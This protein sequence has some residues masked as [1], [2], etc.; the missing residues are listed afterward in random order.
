MFFMPD[1][2]GWLVESNREGEAAQTLSRLR[3]KPADDHSVRFE[4]LEIMAEVRYTR[5]VTKAIIPNAGPYRLFIHK[6]VSFGSRKMTKRLFV[7][8]LPMSFQ[9]NMVGV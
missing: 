4:L 3:R 7:G 2:P 1:S 9:Q 8:C 6:L 5:E